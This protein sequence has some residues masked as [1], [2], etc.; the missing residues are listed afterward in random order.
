METDNGEAKGRPETIGPVKIEWNWDFDNRWHEM[1]SIG[2]GDGKYTFGEGGVFLNKDNCGLKQS[3]TRSTR[4]S[5]VP[6]S[7][8]DYGR[9]GQDRNRVPLVRHSDVTYQSRRW[10]NA[11]RTY[12]LNDSASN[13]RLAFQKAFALSILQRVLSVG[14]H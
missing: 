8:C 3:T 2:S 13:S 11:F 14:M 4:H 10:E 9:C 5:E 6:G 1:K 12:S 7:Y